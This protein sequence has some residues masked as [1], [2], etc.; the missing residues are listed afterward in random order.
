MRCTHRRLLSP[1]HTTFA[2]S[3]LS[4]LLLLVDI[5]S[6]I[7]SEWPPAPDPVNAQMSPGPGLQMGKISISIPSEFS[8]WFSHLHD[9]GG[10]NEWP[11]DFAIGDIEGEDDGDIDIVLYMADEIVLAARLEINWQSGAG[12]LVPLW[13]WKVPN[14][15]DTPPSTHPGH[16]DH[17]CLIWD[18]DNDG[19][20]EVALVAPAQYELWGEP[21]W[22]QAIYVVQEDP[23]P[24]SPPWDFSVPPPLIRAMSEPSSLANSSEI[25]ERLGICRVR[26]TAYRQDI[27]THDHGGSTLSIWRLP[28]DPA[29]NTLE[30]V[31]S[32]SYTTP[33]THEFNHADIDGD[34]FDEFAWDGIL[35]FVDLVG[36]VPTQ[37]NATDPLEGVWR[38]QSGM[39]PYDHMDHMM[40]VDLDPNSPGLEVMSLPEFDWTDPTGATH[41]GVD[42]IWRADGTILRVNDDCPF[43]H[44]QS[45]AIGN[46]TASRE[47]LESIF[48]PKSFSNPTVTGGEIW[49]C[50]A[51]AVD[52]NQNELA[53]DGGYW[54]TVKLNPPENDL[55]IHR[56]TGPA[57]RMWQVDWD[58][59]RTEDEILNRFWQTLIVW[60]MG[61]KGDWGTTP[62][63]GMPTQAQLQQSWTENGFELWWDFYQGYNGA[64]IDEWGWNNGGPGR[65]THYYQ[66]LG[67]AYPG[68]GA[69]RPLA[70]D[71]GRDYREEIVVATPYAVNIFYNLEPANW[72]TPHLSPTLDRQ[73]RRV[74]MERVGEPYIFPILLP[75][76]G[77]LDDDRDV[78]V[79][80]MLYVI[81]M[82]GTDDETAD[83]DGSGDVGIDDHLIV[84][85]NWGD[86]D[87]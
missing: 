73:Y 21:V 20:N 69:W 59:D 52:A 47:G 53:V 18:F 54:Q 70:W 86:C 58:G 8:Q 4:G 24:A 36:G 65:Y 29:S 23:S 71:I 81:A 63:P 48:V 7:D 84:L 50:G 9:V 45:A 3:V 1:G 44:P 80:D 56:A 76:P 33:I 82:W 14:A 34:G 38:W 68:A 5:S 27:V 15:P 39:V 6:G 40:I 51:Y 83:I 67:E 77:D 2:V 17:N 16:A 28:D 66:K 31:F 46:W 13:C 57:Y 49:Q 43:S 35:D 41:P 87:D 30:R 62:P 19:R 78:D 64:K 42:T 79:D 85:D 72:N 12:T 61:E 74:R 26:D 75:C 32:R 60:R 11:L 37:T 55:P 10:W 22:G 25:S